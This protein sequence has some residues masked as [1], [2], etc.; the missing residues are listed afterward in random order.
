MGDIDEE[1]YSYYTPNYIPDPWE[2]D[3]ISTILEEM[4]D[5]KTSVF[6]LDFTL[7]RFAPIVGGEE[8]VFVQHTICNPDDG[9]SPVYTIEKIPPEYLPYPQKQGE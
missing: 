4:G 6:P 9:Q 8:E 5:H 3:L 2:I 1:D 7:L